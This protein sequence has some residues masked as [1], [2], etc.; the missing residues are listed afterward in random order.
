MSVIVRFTFSASAIATP[1]LGP[2]SLS[3]K[4]QTRAGDNDEMI[5]ISYRRQLQTLKGEWAT[6]RRCDRKGRPPLLDTW[7]GE[8]HL[9]R[10]GATPPSRRSSVRHMQ[11]AQQTANF[12]V[13]V[14][15]ARQRQYR[16]ERSALLDAPNSIVDLK[17]ISESHTALWADVVPP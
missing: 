16:G 6:T 1:L 3:L 12:K 14:T 9:N 5:R 2:N 10:M 15:N 13:E 7:D 11:S 8:I 17:R 4:L